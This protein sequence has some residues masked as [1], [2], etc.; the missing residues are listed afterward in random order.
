MS[1]IAEKLYFAPD[2]RFADLDLRGNRLP[3]QFQQ[4]ISGFYLNPAIRL[5]KERHDFASGILAVCAIDALALF[6]TGSNGNVRI[7]AF[8]R[9]HIPDLAAER[10]AG[11]FC[12]HFRNGLLHEAR[13]KSGS[14]F[15]LDIETIAVIQVGY[16][17]VNPL[18]LLERVD[19]VLKEY[20]DFLYHNPQAKNGLAKK[21]KQTFR[22]ELEH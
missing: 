11:M 12:E 16:L 20:V 17:V 15:S 13:V 18:L 2:V 22:F 3:T 9:K 5:A 6:M 7:T 1:R 8:C 10:D 14:E 21:L 4:R 19:E